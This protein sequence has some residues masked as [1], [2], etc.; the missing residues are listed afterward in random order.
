[1]TI[2][3][4]SFDLHH[5]KGSAGKWFWKVGVLFLQGT[6][7]YLLPQVECL[8]KQKRGRWV[9]ACVYM[10]E[11]RK[12][13]REQEV[14]SNPSLALSSRGLFSRVWSWAPSKVVHH[15]R[16]STRNL[17]TPHLSLVC[18][19]VNSKHTPAKSCRVVSSTD[20]SGSELRRTVSRTFAV[21]I[22]TS[23]LK[24]CPARREVVLVGIYDLICW[25]S[26]YQ[27]EATPGW[28]LVTAII[29]AAIRV[30]FEC[31]R[32]SSVYWW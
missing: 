8:L 5:F 4:S 28:L 16:R 6:F 25:I 20:S 12:C 2:T 14:L 23:H 11:Q 21:F 15:L 32:R 9:A 22:I 24:S 29:A 27:E 30:R 3:D 10:N 19:G 31:F 1:M 13:W 7:Q 26:A 17:S 18:L